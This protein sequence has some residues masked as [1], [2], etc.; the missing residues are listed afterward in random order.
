MSYE[1]PM[2]RNSY[3]DKDVRLCNAIAFPRICMCY[4]RH[5][6]LEGGDTG[7]RD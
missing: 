3:C 6:G 4:N 5:P 1:D 2:R 7:V